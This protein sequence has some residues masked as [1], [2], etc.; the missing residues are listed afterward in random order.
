[1]RTD[2]NIYMRKDIYAEQAAAAARGLQR[3][4]KKF[5][6]M[7]SVDMML[8]GKRTPFERRRVI[9]LKRKKA[10]QVSNHLWFISASAQALWSADVDAVG[11]LFSLEATDKTDSGKTHAYTNLTVN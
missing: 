5:K 9:A 8:K 4:K 3:E 10:R 1:M 2:K 11:C 7:T 6:A